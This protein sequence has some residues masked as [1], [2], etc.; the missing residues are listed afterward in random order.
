MENK[1]KFIVASAMTSFIV[2]VAMVVWFIFTYSF[3]S[4]DEGPDNAPIRSIPA[5]FIFCIFVFLFQLA[6][7]TALGNSI[8]KQKSPNIT[9]GAIYA[10]V[11]SS[12]IAFLVFF[13]TTIPGQSE[14]PSVLLR[15][16]ITLQFFAFLWVSFI[17]GAFI[18][19]CL[20]KKHNKA[21]LLTSKQSARNLTRHVQKGIGHCR[22]QK[23]SH[24]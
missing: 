22:K 14:S 2:P 23:T 7:Y 4:P 20:V 8:H 10:T 21:K 16:T 6:A 5:I 17:G 1:P 19:L 24:F 18:Q 11:L 12:P 15:I 9:P 3:T 13:M